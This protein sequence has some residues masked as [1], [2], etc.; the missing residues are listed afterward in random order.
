M[1][2]GSHFWENEWS[3][4]GKDWKNEKKVIQP[5]GQRWSD[6]AKTCID[7]QSQV[8]FREWNQKWVDLSLNSFADIENN[9][10][11][12]LEGYNNSFRFMKA[13]QAIDTRKS[14]P[15]IDEDSHT[16][17]KPFWSGRAGTKRIAVVWFMPDMFDELQKKSLQTQIAMA[18]ASRNWKTNWNIQSEFS[19][20]VTLNSSGDRW[21]LLK[22]HTAEN[23]I[24]ALNKLLSVKAR[25]CHCSSSK[26]FRITR[27]FGARLPQSFWNLDT[28]SLKQILNLIK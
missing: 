19:Q 23:H 25:N 17:A 18:G 13:K 14:D 7:Y 9:L 26:N 22:S 16:F 12:V 2:L 20:F 15:L 21:K 1:W 27:G 3:L 6:T 4:T 10:F 28:T 11:E 24:V 5:S 8:A